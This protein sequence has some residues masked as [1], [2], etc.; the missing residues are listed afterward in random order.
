MTPRKVN[1]FVV[2]LAA[3]FVAVMFGVMQVGSGAS[4]LAWENNLTQASVAAKQAGKPMLVSFHTPGCPACLQM[5]ATTF[6]DEKVV[7]LA[8]NFVC[9]RVDS[10]IDPKA[11]DDAKISEF[12]TTV[13]LNAQGRETFRFAGYI[14]PDR[15]ATLLDKMR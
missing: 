12:P 13:F 6:H 3:L 15:F 8:K 11:T 2:V 14:A 4:G 7:T 5:D 1:S 10:D 9:V